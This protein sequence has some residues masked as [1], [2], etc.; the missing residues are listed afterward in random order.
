MSEAS[1]GGWLRR[2][3]R[4]VPRRIRRDETG[5]STVEFAIVA[6]PFLGA[7]FMM[8]ETGYVFFAGQ[9]LD[10]ATT[11]SARLIL[12]GQSA[13]FDANAFR[14]DLCSRTMALLDCN[15][16]TIVV[17]TYASWAAVDVTPPIDSSGNLTQTTNV[18]NPG[19]GGSIVVVRTLYQYPV[20]I[21]SFGFDLANLAN[22]KRLLI[23][24]VA[25]R[26]EP[27]TT[28]GAN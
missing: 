21:R 6:T 5:T 28:V 18:F 11:D 14:T 16:I 27:F 15:S 26:N 19:A 13:G 24:T 10:S 17:Q 12:T 7:L 23:S 3:R 25:F 4:L 8:V 9:V 22:G 2:L 20:L 1:K